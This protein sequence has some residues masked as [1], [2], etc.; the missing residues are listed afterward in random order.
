MKVSELLERLKTIKDILKEKIDNA[1]SPD[2]VE[3]IDVVIDML[4]M[5][6]YKRPKK[7]GR[8]AKLKAERNNPNAK[9]IEEAMDA[10][11]GPWFGWLKDR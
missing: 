1:A 3:A 5:P 2:L 8:L 9:E 11:F 4:D 10:L 7:T 6:V